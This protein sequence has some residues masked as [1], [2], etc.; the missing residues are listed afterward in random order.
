MN[1]FKPEMSIQEAVKLIKLSMNG[2]IEEVT[3]YKGGNINR[4]FSFNCD[5]KGYVLRVGH[6]QGDTL[7]DVQSKQ[8]ILNQFV[9]GGAP[10]AF[11]IDAGEYGE[12]N[13]QIAERLDGTTLSEL[14]KEEKNHLKQE[15]IPIL[16]R[17]H[18]VDVSS[19]KGYGWLTL[20]GD[21]EFTTWE[22]FARS[23]YL[24]EQQGFWE[25]WTELF[26]T[27]FL[28]RDVFEECYDRMLHYIEYNAPYRYILHNDCHESNIIV[29]DGKIVGLIDGNFMYGDFVKDLA[30]WISPLNNSG[31]RDRFLE[32]YEQ[33]GFPLESLEERLLGCHYF[34]GLDA[35]RFYAKANRRSDYDR[36]RNQLLSFPTK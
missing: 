27:S 7:H 6:K 14:D 30:G 36:V 31:L 3:E 16:S 21:G 4:V 20:T 18:R 25:G 8:Y 9:R 24:P 10:L 22:H 26:E 28:E 23:F 32:T 29:N 13:Y 5:G 19:S 15:L 34:G 33:L 17:M 1:H 2:A 12:M 11:N 35:M